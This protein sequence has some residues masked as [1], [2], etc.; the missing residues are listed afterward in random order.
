MDYYSIFAAAIQAPT[1]LWIQMM[2]EN[3]M[4]MGRFGGAGSAGLLVA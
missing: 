3:G 2:M 4:T 1:M